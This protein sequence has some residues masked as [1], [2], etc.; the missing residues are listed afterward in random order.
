MRKRIDRFI[1]KVLEMDPFRD[2]KSFEDK[3]AYKKIHK[4]FR[5]MIIGLVILVPLAFYVAIEVDWH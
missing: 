5:H 4:S 2:I 3:E 1:D